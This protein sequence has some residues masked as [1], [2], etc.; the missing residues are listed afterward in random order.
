MD[1]V[2]LNDSAIVVVVL[3]KLVNGRNVDNVHVK[4]MMF[5]MRMMTLL[6]M[7]VT[8]MPKLMFFRIFIDDKGGDD[9]A[10][11]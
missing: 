1:D 6:L 5:L 8:I 2:G 11:L 10:A 9:G 4:M 7:M 3:M